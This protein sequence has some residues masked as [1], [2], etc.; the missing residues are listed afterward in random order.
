MLANPVVYFYDCH[1]HGIHNGSPPTHRQISDEGRNAQRS[2]AHLDRL[3]L[4]AVHE[5]DSGPRGDRLGGLLLG[6][7]LVPAACCQHRHHGG[8]QPVDRLS[9][10]QAQISQA[11]ASQND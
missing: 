5:P 11:Q 1:V 8:H 3:P 7:A 9:L 2:A 4:C 10:T 6:C